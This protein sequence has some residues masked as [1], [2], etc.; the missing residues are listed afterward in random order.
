[1]MILEIH[2]EKVGTQK[3]SLR[4]IIYSFQEDKRYIEKILEKTGAIKND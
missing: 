4:S 1:M 2:L 3:K